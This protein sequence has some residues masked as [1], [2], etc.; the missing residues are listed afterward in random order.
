LL[1]R[2]GTSYTVHGTSS[3]QPE[4]RERCKSGCVPAC[5]SHTT[6]RGADDD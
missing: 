3:R 6:D 5:V 4:D 1:D 2:S